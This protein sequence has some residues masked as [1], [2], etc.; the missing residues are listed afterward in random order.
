MKSIRLL[1]LLTI[2]SLLFSAGPI[3]S[4]PSSE[5]KESP[6]ADKASV[7]EA[8]EEYNQGVG[9]MDKARQIAIVGDSAF[10]YNYRATASAKAGR[11]Y[12]KAVENFVKATELNPEYKEAHNNLGFCYRKLGKL[13]ESLAAYDKAIKL[14]KDFAQAREYRGETYL[15]MGEL[16][17]AEA[18]LAQLIQLESLYAD[19][20]AQAIKLYRLNEF[21]RK[22]DNSETDQ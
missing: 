19:T 4:A 20:L 5:T 14:D 3:L 9:H 17:K 11:E 18:E 22:M 13:A 7:K 16:E 1:L 21:S 2:A 6:K 10:A 12:E 8:T 15:A